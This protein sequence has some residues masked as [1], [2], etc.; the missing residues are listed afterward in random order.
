[1]IEVSNLTKLYGPRTAIDSLSFRVEEGEIVGFL[2][3]NGAGKSTTMKIL[4]CFMSATQGEATVAGF[5]V[6]K[7]P[8]EVKKRVGYLA[9][10]PP[11]Y[12]EMQV[13]DYLDFAAR[14]QQVESKLVKSAVDTALER[15]GLGDVRNRLIGNLSK[16][17]RQ[18]VGIA[19]A[20]VHDPKVVILDEPTVGL[21][22]RQIIEIRDL[23]KSLK[24]SHTVILSSHILPEVK[25]TC[26]RILIIHKGKIV[27]KDSIDQ[28]T[29]RLHKGSILSLGVKNPNPAGL[30]AIEGIQ[31]VTRLSTHGNRINI[32]VTN[33]SDDLKSSII[34]MAVR[35]EM[36]VLEFT[37]EGAT[38]EDI[39]LELTTEEPNA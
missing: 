3:P 13:W 18:R 26:D 35:N 29:M 8:L 37:S 4:T 2:G 30:T 6:F 28:L 21:D 25:A 10:N 11:V 5:D 33:S 27:A 31:G 39:F 36:G 22:P 34:D 16:G 1:M 7:Q 15:T 17:F 23:I 19:Q 32:E 9:E 12:L 20:I 14:L 38:L 24:G